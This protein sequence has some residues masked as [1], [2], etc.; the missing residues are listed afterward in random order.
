MQNFVISPAASVRP[1][2]LAPPGRHEDHPLHPR[3]SRPRLSEGRAV[4]DEHGYRV[5]DTEWQRITCFN[6][7]GKS[8]AEN[9][10]KGMKVLVQGR[11]TLHEV[12]RCGGRRPLP[13]ARSSPRRSTSSAAPRLPRAIRPNWSIATTRS[14]SEPTNTG[15]AGITRRARRLPKGQR[16]HS[17][18]SCDKS[19]AK[20]RPNEPDAR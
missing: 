16:R 13:A 19:R 18:R 2:R 4:R 12:D 8:V 1:R 17:C 14:A 3:H 11:I 7:L 10:E 5:M 6:G 9:C 20:P 15:P